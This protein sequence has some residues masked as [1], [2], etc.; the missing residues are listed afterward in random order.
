MTDRK[1]NSAKLVWQ[2][3]I[4]EDGDLQEFAA[5]QL[6]CRRRAVAI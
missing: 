6:G 3:M 5:G 1:E 4:D 2:A